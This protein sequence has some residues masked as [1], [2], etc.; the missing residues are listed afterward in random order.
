MDQDAIN[1]E[2]HLSR[3]KMEQIAADVSLIK[4]DVAVLK[5]EHRGIRQELNE[6]HAQNRKDIHSLRNVLQGS[7]D[8]IGIEID[9][10]WAEIQN[11]KLEGARSKGFW[12]AM[13]GV[14]TF[15]LEM[16]K[17]LVEHF[18]K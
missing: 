3:T 15:A 2:M 6:K 13:G 12:I 1:N 4:S 9:K 10:V 16:L 7:M 18:W 17:L 11:M 8:K 14:A 5:T